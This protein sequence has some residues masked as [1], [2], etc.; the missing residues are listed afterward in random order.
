MATTELQSSTKTK[1]TVTLSPEVVRKLQ[2]ISDARSC[3]RSLLVEEALQRWFREHAQKE[4]ETQVEEYYRALSKAERE[5]DRQ[6]TR[7]AAKSAK[8]LWDK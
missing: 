8:R 7:I 4:L 2:S 1:I 3:S 5:E 6:W